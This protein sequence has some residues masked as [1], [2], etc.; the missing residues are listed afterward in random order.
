MATID[1]VMGLIMRL[2]PDAICENCIEEKLGLPAQQN[3]GQSS[4][5]LT[6]TMGFERR[7]EM[8]AICDE[9]KQVIRFV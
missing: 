7:V 5:Q 2:S 1:R 8:C 3:A 6:V 9:N 4:R